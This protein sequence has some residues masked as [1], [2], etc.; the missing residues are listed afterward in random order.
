[1][2]R[3]RA[4]WGAGVGARQEMVAQLEGSTATSGMALAA[5]EDRPVLG[6]LLGRDFSFEILLVVVFEFAAASAAP[7]SVAESVASA[8]T[9]LVVV[10]VVAAPAVVVVL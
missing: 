9:E 7:G 8:A 10:V 1:M 4:C 5:P 6:S 3:C 2:S